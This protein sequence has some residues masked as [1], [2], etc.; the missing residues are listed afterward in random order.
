MMARFKFYSYNNAS[1]LG[2]GTLVAFQ[3]IMLFL[4]VFIHLWTFFVALIEGGIISAVASLVMPIF[5]EVYWFFAIWSTT[6]T[7]LNPYST[8]VLIFLLAVVAWIAIIYYS[9]RRQFRIMKSNVISGFDF[10]E[11]QTTETEHPKDNRVYVLDRDEYYYE[12]EKRV[13]ALNKKLKSKR[14]KKK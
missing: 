11:N 9:I 8:I 4:G 10:V 6:G 12:P 5:A 1:G 2:C 14:F 13:L 3:T 7:V